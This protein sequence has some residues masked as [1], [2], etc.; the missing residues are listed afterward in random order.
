MYDVTDFV[1]KHPGGDK[2]LLAGGKALE[3]F[4][5]L[6]AIHKSSTQ[7]MPLLRDM[8][9]GSLTEEDK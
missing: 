9:I 3:P 1:A 8:K 6:Y 5:S 4:W 2:I 7:V